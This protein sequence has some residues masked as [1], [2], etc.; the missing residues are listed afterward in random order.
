M[1]SGEA[2][3]DI[4]A[5]L[6]KVLDKI[7]GAEKK[8]GR[9]AHSVSLLAVSKFHSEQSVI[10][11]IQAGQTSFG[12]NR[13]QEAAAKFDS[14]MQKGFS[15]DLHIIGTLQ[16]N[17]VKEAV[18]IASCIESVDRIALLEEIEKQCARIEKHIS[19]YFE[20]HTGEESKSGFPDADSLAQAVSLCAAGT[21]PHIIPKGFMTM[22]PN[23][24][25][26]SAIHFS[27][28]TLAQTAESLRSRFPQLPLSELSMGMSHDFEAAIEEGS[29]EVRIGTAI[30]GE[31]TV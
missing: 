30:F 12:E 1:C 22:A 3:T 19:V 21:F 6:T 7:G 20:L 2:K 27:F 23:T 25:D 10:D 26:D 9:K 16:R 17:K 18:R 8:Y 29:T 13:I 28:K 14:L 4:A 31:R 15:P 11:A 5:N 24:D